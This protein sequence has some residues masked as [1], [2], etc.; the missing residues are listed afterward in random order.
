M[1]RN[2]QRLLIISERWRP[3]DR[4][5]DRLGSIGIDGEVEFEEGNGGKGAVWGRNGGMCLIRIP[6]QRKPLPY[7][8]DSETLQ[9]NSISG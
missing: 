3:S 7:S 1:Q 2:I 8:D 6:E 9:S 5:G 4:N